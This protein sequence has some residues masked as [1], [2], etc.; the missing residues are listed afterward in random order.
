MAPNKQPTAEDRSDAIRIALAGLASG[1]QPEEILSKLSAL[2]IRHNTFP[3]EELLELA[4]NAIEEFGAM[5]AD[6]IDSEGI[7]ERFLPD[8]PFSGKTQHYKSKYAISAAAM[9]HGGVYPD[10]LD[11]AA[12]WQADDLWIYSFFA[13]LLY[14]R[15]AAERTGQ[16]VE[17]VA[18]SIADR[19]GVTLFTA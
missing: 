16:P 6:P 7:R 2:H 12:W 4:S 9:I 15:V 10:L 5:P 8:H 13:F 1:E 11:D 19:R 3:A 17:E 14:V 18:R